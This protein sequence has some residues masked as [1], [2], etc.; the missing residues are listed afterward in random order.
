MTDLV[1]VFDDNNNGQLTLDTS[2]LESHYE[3]CGVDAE[4]VAAVNTYNQAF[5]EGTV[6]HARALVVPLMETNE[7][8]TGSVSFEC[9]INLNITHHFSAGGTLETSA[10]SYKLVDTAEKALLTALTL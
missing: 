10:T 7:T 3:M 8:E 5:A 6:E 9:G 4:G 1:M 2:A